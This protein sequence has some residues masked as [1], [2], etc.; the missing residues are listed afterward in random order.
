M[1]E[2]EDAAQ[3]ARERPDHA[4]TSGCCTGR[5]SLAG[6][7]SRFAP[8]NVRRYAITVPRIPG[9]A[10]PVLIQ[11]VVSR[12][13][14]DHGL[15]HPVA[16]IDDADRDIG[17]VK[18]SRVL[19]ERRC[20]SRCESRSDATSRPMSISARNLGAVL[21]SPAFPQGGSAIGAR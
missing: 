9:T 13:T 11:R 17:R 3:L 12:S 16:R 14:G 20:S 8:R 18:R 2:L 6:S 4:R 5:S 21:R 7:P 1:F 15:Q 19:T 10:S